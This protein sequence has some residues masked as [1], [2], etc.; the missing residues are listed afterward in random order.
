MTIST[1][2]SAIGAG[3]SATTVQCTLSSVPAG[4]TIVL[5]I[6]NRSNE[7][8]AISGISDTVNGAWTP[9]YVSGPV[10]LTGASTIRSWLAYLT[11]VSA[12]S[13]T[14]TITF[15]GAI[16]SQAAAVYISSDLGAITYQTN[17]TPAERT[18]SGTD[19][20]SNT[21]AANGAGCIVG[22]LCT[23]NAQADPEPIADG[24][25]ESRLTAAAAGGRTFIFFES[26][27]SAGTYGFEATID[28]ATAIFL[29]GAFLEPSTTLN[30]TTGAIT[31]NGRAPTT[32]AFQNVRIREVLV[33]ASGQAVG[34]HTDIGLRVWYGGICQGAP[35]VS[36]N[37]LTTDAN[38]TTSWSI[39]TGTLAFNDPIFYV[40]QNSVSYSTYTA[41]RLVPSYE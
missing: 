31:L 4:A 32:S 41:A 34:S 1:G 18:T 12:G 8:A 40:A 22:S 21:I 3:A 19:L 2:A 20:D 38:G 23:N 14:I 6:H 7:T 33:N 39:A 26:F 30:P 29:V 17:A 27:A 36:L 9:N 15:D 28:S 37:G 35:D 24:A 10:D 5:A 25:G 13:P 11:N 16:N